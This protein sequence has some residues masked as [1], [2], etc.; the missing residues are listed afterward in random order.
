MFVATPPFRV[1]DCF[2]HNWLFLK[3]FSVDAAE[4]VAK[5][6][7]TLYWIGIFDPG[8]GGV[9]VPLFVPPGLITSRLRNYTGYGC[10]LNSL[11][12]DSCPRYLCSRIIQQPFGQLSIYVRGRRCAS[13]IG[14]CGL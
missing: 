13:K 7:R 2:V 6:G 4:F 14:F 11:C 8:G 1:P 5:S 9:H 3:R 10:C 12:A